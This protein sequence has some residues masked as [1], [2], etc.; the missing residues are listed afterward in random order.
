MPHGGF[1]RF[2]HHIIYG[3]STLEDRGI[4]LEYRPFAVDAVVPVWP[5]FAYW[6]D[7]DGLQLVMP[8]VVQALNKVKGFGGICGETTDH[9]VSR[10]LDGACVPHQCEYGYYRA[11]ST[12]GLFKCQE[13][14]DQFLVHEKEEE[15]E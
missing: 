10:L 2:A 8:Q 11:N 1:L 6:T 15:E 12:T 14:V 3:Y 4:P 9:V 7:V 5:R 13:R